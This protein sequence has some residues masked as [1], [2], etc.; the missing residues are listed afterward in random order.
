MRL[1]YKTLPARVFHKELVFSRYT[2]AASKSTSKDSWS[3]QTNRSATGNLKPSTTS[4]RLSGQIG[5]LLVSWSPVLPVTDGQVRQ[6]GLLQLPCNTVPP[7]ACSVFAVRSVPCRRRMGSWR[8][9]SL[10]GCGCP[11][12]HTSLARTSPRRVVG[13]ARS[14]QAA[15][16]A[17]PSIPEGCG[18]WVKRDQAI[19]GSYCLVLCIS[20][21]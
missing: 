1:L 8:L 9:R 18:S 19:S 17:S 21:L 7:A 11:Y 15:G 16:R 13:R 14:N 20:V 3:G 12:Q 4:D 2:M 5:L 10:E 6:I